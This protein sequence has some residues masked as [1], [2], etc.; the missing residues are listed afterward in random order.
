LLS[1]SVKTERKEEFEVKTTVVGIAP[2]A[3]EGEK[4]A[5]ALAH[6][7]RARILIELNQRV[8]S[9][10]GYIRM[11]PE[12]S[13]SKVYGHFRA[14]EKYGCIELI[15][16][17]TGG[18]RRGGVERFYRATQRSLF[19]ESTWPTLPES[20]K[21]TMTGATFSSYVQRAV[22]AINGKTI[23][24]REDRHLSWSPGH[25]DQQAWDETIRDLDEVFERLPKRLADAAARL[26]E[27]GEESI[28][29]TIALACFESPRAAVADE[30]DSQ[31][32]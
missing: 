26:A 3:F 25:I 14:L 23:D 7:L 24:V 32:P 27:K 31:Q 28:P 8:M 22:D 15:E 11:F 19:D 13:H 9:V 16:T 21:T 12:H 4:L 30:E 2:S 10:T 18:K 5:K 20:A 1:R 6:P 17:K 29:V